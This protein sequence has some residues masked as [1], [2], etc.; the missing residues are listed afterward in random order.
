[1][2]ATMTKKPTPFGLHKDTLP[3][4][5]RNTRIVTYE[6]VDNK[7]ICM[8][9]HF[10]ADIYIPGTY[11]FWDRNIAET[12]PHNANKM[13]QNIKNF[14]WT[15]DI[16]GKDVK[17]PEVKDIQMEFGRVQV[18]VKKDY[19]LFIFL[20]L[21]DWNESNPNRDKTKPVIYRRITKNKPTT[22]E[23]Y[24]NELLVFQ[25]HNMIVKSPFEKL[26]KVYVSVI[27][28]ATNS[29]A[30]SWTEGITSVDVRHN[31]YH[32]ASK[33]PR[34]FIMANPESKAIVSMYISDAT[35]KGL[36]EL[37]HDKNEW[38]LLNKTIHKTTVGSD[39][40]EDLVKFIQTGEGGK[41]VWESLRK[42]VDEE[43]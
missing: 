2:E 23:M 41:K 38:V 36:L 39:P 22:K 13:L 6:A 20:E 43:I 3:K 30:F 18:D 27:D 33:H 29:A 21:S 26:R 10:P 37:D 42:T 1:M 35:T 8:S 7:S 31:L 25:A 16:T 19:N 14:K 32:F 9:E 40:T 15:K 17:E 5:G 28:P 34:A 11:N 24:D 4:L 12:D